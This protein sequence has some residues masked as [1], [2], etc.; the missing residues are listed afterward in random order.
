MGRD[1]ALLP[2]EGATLL[3]HAIARLPPCCARRADPVRT[4]A[5]LRGPR[6]AA[7]ASMRHRRRPA[8][9]VL[10]GL[11]ATRTA[12]ALFLAVDLPLVPVEPARAIWPRCGGGRRGR[13]AGRPRAR[14]AVRRSTRRPA[15]SPSERRAGR[16]R[17]EDDELLAGR[18]RPGG[19]R[20]RAGARSATR[21]RLFHN[22]N[23]PERLD[24]ADSG[25]RRSLSWIHASRLGPAQ[26]ARAG[27]DRRRRRADPRLRHAR[28]GARGAGAALF[29]GLAAL[30]RRRGGARRRSPLD[31]PGPRAP[32]ADLRGRGTRL[33]GARDRPRSADGHLHRARAGGAASTARWTSWPRA[34]RRCWRWTAAPSPPR[35]Q[36]AR[37]AS[38]STSSMPTGRYCYY[39]AHLDAY[40]AGLR[41]GAR[42]RA[43]RS[44]ATWGPRATRP[45]ARPHL[46]FAI[47]RL[48]DAKQWWADRP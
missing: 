26:P 38:P 24:S 17:P 34:A 45:A 46:H 30:H 2:W 23:T 48:S 12:P 43:G 1:K 14:A 11:L 18:P 36:R 3:D 25:R 16:G 27:A 35:P 29:A 31:R 8:G 22:V 47:Y 21:R 41:E 33:P 13:A 4:R 44:S 42:V 5:A 32:S 10:T 19:G 7:R 39:Y 15:S 6:R 40:A 37:G 28:R 20:R 9:A